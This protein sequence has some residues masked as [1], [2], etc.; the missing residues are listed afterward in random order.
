VRVF[1]ARRAYEQFRKL[2]SGAA[3]DGGRFTTVRTVRTSP[4]RRP[5]RMAAATAA[6]ALTLAA[7][8]SGDGDD[9]AGSVT[10]ATIA[11]VTAGAGSDTTTTPTDDTTASATTPATD[12]TTTPDPTAAAAVVPDILQFSAPLVGGGTFDGAAVAGIPTAFWFWA[13]T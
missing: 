5:H 12:G 6:M 10:S 1:I 4:K 11:D 9:A 3:H 8:G 13:P 7:C 2:G